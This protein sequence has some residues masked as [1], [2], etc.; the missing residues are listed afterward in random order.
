MDLGLGE[1]RDLL[2][3]EGWGKG[4]GCTRQREGRE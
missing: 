4:S 2:G 1:G 3:M